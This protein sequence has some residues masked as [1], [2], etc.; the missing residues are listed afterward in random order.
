MGRVDL[1][2]TAKRLYERF[3]VPLVVGGDVAVGPAIGARAALSL[4]GGL[5]AVDTDVRSQVDVA[6]VR[7]ARRLS[8]VDLLEG[9]DAHEWALAAALHDL[10]YALH[11]EL[12]GDAPDRLLD[13]AHQV[14]ARVAPPASLAE[15]ISRHTLFAR[16][17]ELRRTDTAVS[18]WTGSRTFLGR[19]PPSRLLAWPRLRRVQTSERTLTLDAMADLPQG[20]R[21]RFVEGIA[22][23]LEKTPLTDLATCARPF[24]AFRWS[25]ASLGL[26]ARPNGRVLGLRA[27]ALGAREEVDAALGRATRPHVEAGASDDVARI[28]S[29]LAE[30]AL[31]NP[32]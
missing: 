7:V 17:F 25:G 3:L 16:M 4:D 14:L 9:P 29:V 21:D 11:P 18:W 22:R 24:P 2:A 19:S 13:L 31:A 12:G 8:P 28:R 23:L 10:V 20:R 15:A 30:R 27:L 26:F 1:A 6:R 32:R 5:A